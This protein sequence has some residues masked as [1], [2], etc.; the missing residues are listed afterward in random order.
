[1]HGA[2]YDEAIQ[3]LQNVLKMDPDQS[4]SRAYLGYTYA[5]NGMYPQAIAEYQKQI[6]IDGETTSAL[7]YLG[8]A[9][10][11]SGKRSEAQAI[12]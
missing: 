11:M 1:L 2:R 3:Q 7:C 6:T 8:Y 10:A 4:I 5:A 12:R 9:L